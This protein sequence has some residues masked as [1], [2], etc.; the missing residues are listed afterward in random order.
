METIGVQIDSH[1]AGRRRQ[2]STASLP[3]CYGRS[4]GS[5]EHT[6]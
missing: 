5:Y 4:A 3:Y 2:A 1:T 6:A